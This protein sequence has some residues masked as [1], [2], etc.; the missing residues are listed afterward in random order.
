VY[1]TI[2][3]DFIRS[4][5]FGVNEIIY[6]ISDICWICEIEDSR[7]LDGEIHEQNLNDVVYVLK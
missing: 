1:E 4:I 3:P 6:K 7:G 2:N 5:I